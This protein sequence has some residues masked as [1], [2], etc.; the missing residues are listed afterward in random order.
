M[1]TCRWATAKKEKNGDN[2]QPTSAR[3]TNR[4]SVNVDHLRNQRITIMCVRVRVDISLYTPST[5]PSFGT[6]RTRWKTK[7]GRMRLE[8]RWRCSVSRNDYSFAWNLIKF[9]A[10][11]F[12]HQFQRNWMHENRYERETCCRRCCR[13]WL[14]SLSSSVVLFASLSVALSVEWSRGTTKGGQNERRKIRRR[15]MCHI[16]R[17]V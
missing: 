14:L 17:S 16:F 6:Q 12:L 15:N 13:R 11:F 1:H 8:Q 4:K 3:I 5:S 9:C 2:R 7:N 10:A